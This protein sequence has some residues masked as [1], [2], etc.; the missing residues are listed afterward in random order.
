MY[1]GTMIEDLMNAVCRAEEKARDEEEQVRATRMQPLPTYLF[2]FNR[3][4]TTMVWVA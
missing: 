1:T 2:D 4:E 3:A